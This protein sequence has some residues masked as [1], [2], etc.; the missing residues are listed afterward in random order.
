MADRP[1]GNTDARSRTRRR[2]TPRGRGA[3]PP[4]SCTTRAAAG[5]VGHRRRHRRHGRRHRRRRRTRARRR[6][7]T[8]RERFRAISTSFK[9]PLRAITRDHSASASSPSRAVALR[10]RPSGCSVLHVAA[11]CPSAATPTHSLREGRARKRPRRIGRRP[12]WAG[13]VARCSEH[14]C[15]RLRPHQPAQAAVSCGRNDRMYTTAAPVTVRHRC[16]R[17]SARPVQ[18]TFAHDNTP[19]SHGA[20]APLRSRCATG[21]CT[22]LCARQGAMAAAPRSSRM[23]TPLQT[24]TPPER[25]GPVRG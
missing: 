23:A 15:A 3:R 11:A 6:T 7:T 8:G 12:R 4:A 16:C 5:T 1:G 21:S 20:H 13:I 17:F 9:R 10:A 24:G 25:T 18:R 22:P 14:R 2:R 19:S